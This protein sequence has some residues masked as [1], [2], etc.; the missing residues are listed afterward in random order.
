SVPMGK[1]VM[2]IRGI[3]VAGV[4]VDEDAIPLAVVEQDC[5]FGGCEICGLRVAHG[6][7]VDAQR[8]AQ[9]GAD[10]I[11]IVNAVVED[12]EPW[13]GC[14][15]GP[16]LPRSVGANLYFHV[17]QLAKQSSPV[18]RDGGEVV[19]RISQLKVNCRYESALSAMVA[20]EYCLFKC[21]SHWFLNE[22]CGARGELG[23]DRHDLRGRNRYVEDGVGRREAHGFGDGV[24]GVGNVFLG[25]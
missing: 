15:E 6:L 2:R 3:I 1:A 22:N 16:Q 10:E 17:V 8:I 11:E 23:Q 21:L 14:E 4:G 20:Y 24:E 25:R 9:P 12:L 7:C 19:W 5:G 18:E 13:S